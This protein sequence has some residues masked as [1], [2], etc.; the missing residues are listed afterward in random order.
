MVRNDVLHLH[1]FA[2]QDR[3]VSGLRPPPRVP[4][5]AHDF[6]QKD[7]DNPSSPRSVF[8]Q[9]RLVKPLLYKLGARAR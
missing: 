7:E 2:R 5:S 1:N 4:L 3:I 9:R 6:P 8:L